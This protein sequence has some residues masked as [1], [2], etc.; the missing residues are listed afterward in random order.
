[1]GTHKLRPELQNPAVCR[2]L[3]DDLHALACYFEPPILLLYVWKELAERGEAFLWGLKNLADQILFESEVTHTDGQQR[4][5]IFRI[6]AAEDIQ[7]GS[8]LKKLRGKSCIG[9]EQHRNFAFDVPRVQMRY[10]PRR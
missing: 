9:S 8:M 3:F 4:Q 1:G 7:I 2:I 10:G 6:D 5:Y